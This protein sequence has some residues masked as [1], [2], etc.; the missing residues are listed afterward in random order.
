MSHSGIDYQR[1]VVHGHA[2]ELACDVSEVI[3]HLPHWLGLFDAPAWPE[4]LVPARG[5]VDR[6]SQED[7]LRN[8]SANAI[9][10]YHPEQ[11]LD[12]YRDAERYWLVDDRWG[13]CQLNLLK[14]TWQSWVIEHPRMDAVQL[15][16]W[17]VLWPMAQVL[18]GK[19][20]H[21]MPA[22]A[23]SRDGYGLLLISPVGLTREL[24]AM[25]RS[26]WRII[27]QR[28]VALREEEGRIGMLQMPGLLESEPDSSRNAPFRRQTPYVDLL[29]T[30]LGAGQHHAFCDA[31]IL[32]IPGRRR[33]AA[34]HRLQ[35]D[36]ALGEL[37][38]R[39]PIAELH[40]VR[41]HGMAHRLAELCAVYALHLGREPQASV[42]LLGKLR[43]GLDAGPP[44][45]IDIN[46]AP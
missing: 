29:A 24:H 14:R 46:R 26:G 7:V 19:G 36:E 11:H 23:V 45:S 22:T 4:T 28:W 18:R 31:V 8:V 9:A 34:I 35:G 5:R 40:P 38:R 43:Y 21:L 20:L 33:P 16:E 32:A 30:H 17:S 2:V 42:D 13:I 39:W 27:G 44:A 25:A 3:D 37:R 6:F 41:A 10:C 1:L 15:L 12:L